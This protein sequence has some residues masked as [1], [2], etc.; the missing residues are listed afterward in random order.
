M[1]HLTLGEA[2]ALVELF[3]TTPEL[4]DVPELVFRQLDHVAARAAAGEREA[5]LGTFPCPLL[6][7]E[8]RC[9]VYAARPW[10]CV[11][12]QS[13]DRR[14]CETDAAAGRRD[15]WD[16]MRYLPTLG[17]VY[18]RVSA[19]TLRALHEA[20]DAKRSGNVLPV[21]LALAMVMVMVMDA[22]RALG[23]AAAE[24]QEG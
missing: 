21:T 2:S 16:P 15:A 19:G 7:S 13:P 17:D 22:P 10:A 4:M 9:R 23:E 11:L 3:E 24:P 14:A 20:I 6:S 8:R 1:P 5:A 12:C 18:R